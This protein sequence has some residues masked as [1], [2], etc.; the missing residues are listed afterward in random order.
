M[1]RDAI[2]IKTVVGKLEIEEGDPARIDEALLEA[3]RVFNEVL[4]KLLSGV[5][6]KDKDIHSFLLKNTKQRVV[7]K[8]KETFRSF[9]EL[10]RK[11][12]AEELGIYENKPLP[13]KMNFGEGYNLCSGE[14]GSIRFRIS[15]APG[16]HVRGH[17]VFSREHEEII[18][19]AL[20]EKSGQSEYKIT[21]AELVKRSEE[22]YLHIVVTKNTPVLAIRYAVGIDI[23]ED[24]VA[25]TVYDLET[26]EVVD[27]FIVDYSIIK[28]IRHYW[29]TIR[30]RIQ[31]HGGKRKKLAFTRRESRQI[32]HLLHI[33]SKRIVDYLSRYPGI[34]VFMEE[35]TDIRNG[36]DKGKRMN[37][38]LHS[39][40]FYKLQQFLKYKLEWMGVPVEFVP[41]KGTSHRCPLCGVPGTRHK[42][43]FKCPNGH[44]GHADRNASVNILIRGCVMHLHVPHSAFR[45]MKL[46]NFQMWKLRR[47]ESGAWGCVSQ[48]LPAGVEPFTAAQRQ[49]AEKP[50]FKREE[51]PSAWG[52]S[53]PPAEFE[54]RCG[55]DAR[56]SESGVKKAAGHD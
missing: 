20:E 32:K 41:P 39:W 12:Q 53:Q 8:A 44:I 18:K 14:D 15:L 35:L 2:T 26:K 31:K 29:F 37:R 34:I 6:V 16:K 43:M 21:M 46:S 52:S 11:G 5:K 19:E 22:Y 47:E 55:S 56:S 17:L 33:I 48:P 25:I 7:A 27:T 9:N 45:A 13:L 50:R 28:F 49:E 51:A 30:K 40:S 4:T 38:R 24:N 42:K 23:N 54:E 1:E 36:D 10:K 3:R